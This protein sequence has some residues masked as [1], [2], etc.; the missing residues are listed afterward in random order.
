MFWLIIKITYVRVR[1]LN[2][3]NFNIAAFFS[4]IGDV[5]YSVVIAWYIADVLESGIWMGAALFSLGL[6]RFIAALFCGPIID[7]VGAKL[8]MLVSDVI[9]AVIVFIIAILLWKH[10]MSFVALVIVSILFG[11]IDAFYWPAA[12]SIKPRLVSSEYLSRLNSQ[13][14]TVIRITS[15]LGPLIAAWM[16][17]KISI[18]FVLTIIS[19]IYVFSTVSILLIKLKNG[20]VENTSNQDVQLADTSYFS[21][22]KNGFQFLKKQKLLFSLIITMFFVN[23][24]ANGVNALLPFLAKLVS[25]NASYLG[26]VYSSMSIGSLLIGIVFSIKSIKKVVVRQIYLCFLVQAAGITMLSFTKNSFI[27]LVF[28]FIV[29]LVTGAIGVLLPTFV[30]NSIPIQ[31]LGRINSLVMAISMLSTPMAQFIF[32]MSVDYF[33]INYLF[34][35]AGVFGMLVSLSSLLISNKEKDISKEVAM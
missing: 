18:N 20:T 32:G 3:L 27:I 1:I 29:G 15:I 5:I 23:I 26:C 24:G 2:T 9:R 33:R 31:L 14:L 13:Y 8:C 30:Q 19:L 25:D 16:I 28:I 11:I 6:S 34:L 12:E 7:Q 10:M 35:I 21:Q 22:L 4:S 17:D